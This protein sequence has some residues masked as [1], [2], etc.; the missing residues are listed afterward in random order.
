MT[1]SL[2]MILGPAQQPCRGSSFGQLHRQL[3]EHLAEVDLMER[4]DLQTTS[5]PTGQIQL[6]V[7]SVLSGRCSAG[8]EF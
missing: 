7:L 4:H 1:T 2:A 6:N 5:T 3:I 8:S